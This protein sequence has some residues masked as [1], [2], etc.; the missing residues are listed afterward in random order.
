MNG[1]IRQCQLVAPYVRNLVESYATEFANV[2]HGPVGLQGV[3][4]SSAIELPSDVEVFHAVLRV[5]ASSI[6]FF[7]DAEEIREALEFM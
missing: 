5:Q 2:A 6:R 4:L 3:H 1:F 7:N